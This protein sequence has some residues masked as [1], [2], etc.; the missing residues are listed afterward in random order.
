MFQ[1]VG[2][3][4]VIAYTTDNWKPPWSRSQK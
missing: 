4:A 3:L 1:R 2:N